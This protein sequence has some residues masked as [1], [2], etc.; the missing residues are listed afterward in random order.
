MHTTTPR[1]AVIFTSKRTKH[2]Q[3]SYE[4]MAERMLEKVSL[5]E[6]FISTDSLKDRDGFGITVSYWTSIEAIKRWKEET[7]HQC[8]QKLGKD[9][10]YSSYVVRICRIDE[11]YSF[12]VE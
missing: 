8:A 4:A 3:D 7:D 6:G 11:Q 9:Q 1:Y 12:S 5:I 10:W 2:S